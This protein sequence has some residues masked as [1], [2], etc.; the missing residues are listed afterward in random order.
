MF[1]T[2]VSLEPEVAIAIRQL[3][4]VQGKSQAEVI[5]EALALYTRKVSPPK[6]QGIG[7]YC[8]GRTDVSARAEDLMRQSAKDGQWP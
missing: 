6:P 5:R 4:S 3:A 1:K 2:T 7:A 8:S